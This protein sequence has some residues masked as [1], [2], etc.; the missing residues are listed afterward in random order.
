MRNE[1]LVA[2]VRADASLYH[3]AKRGLAVP[4]TK[5]CRLLA[6]EIRFSNKKNHRFTARSDQEARFFAKDIMGINNNLTVEKFH[7]KGGVAIFCGDRQIFPP[8]RK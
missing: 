8:L 4:K 6:Y 7:K 2:L 3:D 1:L 5:P